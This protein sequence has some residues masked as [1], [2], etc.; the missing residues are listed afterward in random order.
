[1]LS[2]QVFCQTRLVQVHFTAFGNWAMEFLPNVHSGMDSHV[3]EETALN[4]E[5]FV[6]HSAFILAVALMNLHVA[7]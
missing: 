7:E 4:F 6:T 3:G 5:C 1:M 2:V